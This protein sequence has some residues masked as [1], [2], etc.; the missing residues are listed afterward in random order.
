MQYDQYFAG[1]LRRPPLA[2]EE[3]LRHAIASLRGRPARG[4]NRFRVENLHQ[5]L[6]SYQRMWARTV[7]SIEEG[8]H[9]RDVERARKMLGGER[10]GA[11]VDGIAHGA[12][13]AERGPRSAQGGAGQVGA[14]QVENVKL[15]RLYRAWME[16]RR[17]CNDDSRA[18]TFDQMA[19]SIQK[20]I[21]QL[22]QKHPGKTIDFQV[23]IR[24]GKSFLRAVTKDPD[25][26]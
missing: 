8:T 26:K 9:R 21:P 4:A 5:R 3:R 1:I 2:E 19:A 16:A 6:L 25:G 22:V 17:R 14:G 11:G 13:P 12:D 23:V 7:R 15:Q 18:P 20:Q 10:A 24:D